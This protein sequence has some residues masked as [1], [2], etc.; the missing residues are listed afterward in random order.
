[1]T[2]PDP[3]DH[4]LTDPRSI[5][6]YRLDP[7]SGHHHPGPPP[8]VG[9][10]LDPGGRGDP[11]QRLR[12]HRRRRTTG[13][14]GARLRGH[15]PAPARERRAGR[16]RRDPAGRAGPGQDPDHPV[17]GRP[18][19]RVAAHRG[20]LGDQ[21]RPVP[22]DLPVRQGPAGR[23]GRRPPGGVGPP[24]RPLRR[25]AG[26]PGH[27]HRRPHRRGRPDQGGRGSLPV[28][29]ADHPLRAGT[30]AQPGH[31]RRQRAPRPGRAD[32]GRAAQRARGAGRPD[33]RPP[34][35]PAARHHAGG[36][37][38]P[39]GLHQPGPDHHPA[40]GP[41][42]RPDPH[43]LPARRGHRA[44]HRRGGGRPS[45]GEAS[46]ALHPGRPTPGYASRCPTSWPRWWPS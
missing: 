46:P 27:L 30:P 33:P 25:E 40:E 5:S 18:A 31:L 42:R 39:R 15:R 28:R 13:H 45:R 44:A 24:Q 21:R 32:P 23:G 43:P 7:S 2:P 6:R 10:A 17:H 16:T 9:V 4:R 36:H 20:P 26:H 3:S 35:P 22:P 12:A 38:Q 14:R 37:G 19:R 1:M 34:G 8:R 11:A 41:V 29:R